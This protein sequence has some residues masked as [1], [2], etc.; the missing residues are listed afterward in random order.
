[1]AF[2]SNPGAFAS[3][4][5]GL[6][7]RKGAAKPAMRPQGFGQMGASL[8]DLG[9]ND[10][11]FEAPKPTISTQARDAD[12]DAFGD[13]VAEQPLRNP[14]AAL[15]PSPVHGQQAELAQ[16]LA[17][18]SDEG[19]EEEIAE[20][21]EAPP[22]P[23][24]VL[25]IAKPVTASPLVE[26]PAP[27]AREASVVEPARAAEPLPDVVPPAVAAPAAIAPLKARA[28]ATT[29][30]KAAFTLRLD[31]ARHLRLRLA[32]AMTGRS[33]QMLVTEAV[34]RLIAD[35]PE[36]DS[37]AGTL[38]DGGRSARAKG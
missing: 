18:A 29:G 5:S 24:P 25:R 11:G 9:W 16:R 33:A 17:A 8:E 28:V 30:P 26:T 36:L 3:L 13:A 4:S 6:L 10:M 27:V 31:Q 14:V 37:F 1:M 35:Y 38:P 34:D 22:A 2:N 7:A 15:T 20:E 19:E 32:C 12:H 23:T 21:V